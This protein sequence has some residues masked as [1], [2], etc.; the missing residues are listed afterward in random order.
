MALA[1]MGPDVNTGHLGKFAN[2]GH[3]L[4]FREAMTA[5]PQPCRGSQIN[6]VSGTDI[7]GKLSVHFG[8]AGKIGR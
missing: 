6:A 7:Q 3:F 2:A 8:A 1:G 4:P 5:K